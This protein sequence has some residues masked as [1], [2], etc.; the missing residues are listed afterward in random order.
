VR[1]ALR[2][3]RSKLFSQIPMGWKGDEWAGRGRIQGREI[4]TF[5]F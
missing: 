2:L 1:L 5:M 4:A 3:A